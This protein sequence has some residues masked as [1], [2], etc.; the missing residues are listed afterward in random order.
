MPPSLQREIEIILIR[1][2]ASYVKLPLF[3]IAP[4]GDVVY[5][6][7]SAAVLL[8]RPFD[9]SGPMTADELA[10]IFRT[11]TEGEPLPADSLPAVR[12]WRTRRPAYGR[13]QY[14]ALDGR[15]WD[16]EVCAMPLIGLGERY[17]GVLVAFWEVQPA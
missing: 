11:A 16:I 6:N 1:R 4:E 5:Y 7:D 8:G 3:L 12:A 2:W 13:I 15:N 9:E 14:H 17:L 10:D